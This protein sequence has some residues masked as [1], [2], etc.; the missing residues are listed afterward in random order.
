[1]KQNWVLKKQTWHLRR[2]PKRKD[3]PANKTRDE[4]GEIAA[5]NQRHA[6]EHKLF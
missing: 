6:K 3:G 4:E 5:D 2:L 1:M